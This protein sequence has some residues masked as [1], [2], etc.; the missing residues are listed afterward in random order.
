MVY[1]YTYLFASTPRPRPRPPRYS[2]MCVAGGTVELSSLQE[3]VR[4]SKVVS[5]LPIRLSDIICVCCVCGVCF[6]CVYACLCVMCVCFTYRDFYPLHS[7]R[8][9]D[10]SAK[11]LARNAVLSL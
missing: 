6:V 7:S 5:T 4:A 11:R 1:K 2:G 9:G 3:P 8:R 10:G